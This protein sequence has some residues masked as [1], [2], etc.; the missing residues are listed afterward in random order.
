MLCLVSADSKVRNADGCED[1]KTEWME[2]SKRGLKSRGKGFN[3]SES[4]EKKHRAGC[5]LEAQRCSHVCSRPAVTVGLVQETGGRIWCPSKVT[6]SRVAEEETQS[7]RVSRAH[8]RMKRRAAV[9]QITF[10]DTL[11][12]V[13]LSNACSKGPQKRSGIKV[14]IVFC[15]V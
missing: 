13:T 3:S 7:V 9:L 2:E 14:L 4:G 15:F 5:H 6:L 1:R 11:W 10:T 8:R 12:Y